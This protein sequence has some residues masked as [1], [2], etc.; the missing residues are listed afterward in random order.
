M[1]KIT[2]KSSEETKEL[3]KKIASQLKGGEVLCLEGDLGGGKTTF[4]QGLLESLGAQGPYTSPTFVVMKKY[5]IDKSSISS[6]YHIDAYRVDAS[7]V[8]DLG[9][10]EIVSDKNSV[11]IVEW[12]E[13][14]SGIL[15]GDSFWITFAWTDENEREILLDERFDI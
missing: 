7:G 15:P 8:L 13:R 12:P 10:D 9:W 2:T 1:K 14:V 4:S 6:V 3:S 11:V 5:E